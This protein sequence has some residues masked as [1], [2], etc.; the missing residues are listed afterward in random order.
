MNTKNTAHLRVTI[1]ADNHHMLGAIAPLL[2]KDKGRILDEALAA[3]FRRAK[4]KEVIDHHR[5]AETVPSAKA[6]AVA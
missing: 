3:Y 1:D 5:L 6:V 4:V 2:G